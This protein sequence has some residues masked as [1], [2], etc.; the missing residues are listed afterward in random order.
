[1]APSSASRARKRWCFGWHRHGCIPSAVIKERRKELRLTVAIRRC[2]V[3][4]TRFPMMR[5]LVLAC[6][7]APS[8]SSTPHRLALGNRFGPGIQLAASALTTDGSESL[9]TD[10]VTVSAPETRS[11]P[12]TNTG[13]F[14][15]A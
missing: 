15:A 2:P 8:R 7:T 3:A 1:M 11:K 6:R 5:V 10:T 12:Y 9:A 13:I 14:A 4:G